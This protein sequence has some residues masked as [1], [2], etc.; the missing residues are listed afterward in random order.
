MDEHDRNKWNNIL[1][2]LIAINS[3]HAAQSNL[4]IQCNLYQNSNVILHK[5]EKI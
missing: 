4:E 3:I 2:L 5:N 1:C